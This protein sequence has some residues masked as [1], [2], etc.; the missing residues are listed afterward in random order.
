MTGEQVMSYKIPEWQ[1]PM[2]LQH[3]AKGTADFPK[4]RLFTQDQIK[5][6]TKYRQT[7]F[8]RLQAYKPGLQYQWPDYQTLMW[9][10]ILTYAN[11][12]LRKSV[13]DNWE[14]LAGH[15]SRLR[16][17]FDTELKRRL[18]NA[19]PMSLARRERIIKETR[20]DS[21]HLA[22]QDPRTLGLL[23]EAIVGKS[24]YGI[25]SRPQYINH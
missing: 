24:F 1:L 20:N 11:R 6:A 4:G 10:E 15:N 9:Q 3:Y 13:M 19:G 18:R 2:E 25:P 8:R 16:S 17:I 5:S 22:I 7:F 12:V 23:E 14:K 21:F